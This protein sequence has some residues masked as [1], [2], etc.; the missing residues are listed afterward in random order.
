MKT[1]NLTDII[2]R[3][4][5]NLKYEVN[6]LP[7]GGGLES[8]RIHLAE[9]HHMIEQFNNELDDFDRDI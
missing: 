4:I 2:N 8:L 7:A 9:L 1:Q 3:R 6:N 5:D